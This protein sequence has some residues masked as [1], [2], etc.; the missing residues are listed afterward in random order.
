MKMIPLS[1]LRRRLG[2]WVAHVEHQ[3]S[4]VIILRHG[5][6]AAALVTMD[7][8]EAL[9]EADGKELRYQEYLEARRLRRFR[10][11]KERLA[12]GEPLRLEE[13]DAED[14]GRAGA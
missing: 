14:E 9:E 10:I 5:R 2:P 1:R 8:L 6:P 12:R 11:L 3:Q 13:M 7:D 4:R